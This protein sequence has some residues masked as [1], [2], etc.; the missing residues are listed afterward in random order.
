[1]ETTVSVSTAAARSIT[2][3]PIIRRSTLKATPR[4]I[5][6]AATMRI[7]SAKSFLQMLLEGADD[8]AGCFVRICCFD[9]E[10][11]NKETVALDVD[12][13][14]SRRQCDGVRKRQSTHRSREFGLDPNDAGFDVDARRKD[15][16]HHIDIRTDKFDE[17]NACIE[18]E[19]VCAARRDAD[20]APRAGPT[21]EHP[22]QHHRYRCASYK[23]F[24]CKRRIRRKPKECEKD[25]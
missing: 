14:R 6:I 9:V 13:K 4:K 12:H 10:P 24:N 1:M 8:S 20:V 15:V 25:R 17:K 5:R 7:S 16:A 19:M 11:V 18:N 2:V 22:R 21:R 3:R 23:R